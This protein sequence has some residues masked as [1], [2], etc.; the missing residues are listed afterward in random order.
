MPARTGAPPPSPLAAVAFLVLAG[1]S[2]A[3]GARPPERAAAQD[4]VGRHRP[5]RHGRDEP[6]AGHGRRDPRP[7]GRGQR[8]RRGDRRQR[9]ARRRRADVVRDRRR[10]V[11]D[12]LGREDAE[13][14]RPQRQRPGPLRR[15]DRGLTATRGSTEIPTHGPLSWSVPGCVDGWDQL[16][17]RFGT[18][19][20]ADLLAPAIA[21]RR[22]GLPRQRDHRRRLAGVGA[23]LWPR[24]RPRPPASSPA[25]SAPRTGDVFRNPGLARS[26]RADRRRTAATPSTAA[27]S[28]TRSS[29]TRSRS[30]AC[31][32]ART[33]R[34]TR[35]PG[36]SPSRPTT[37]ATT[38]GSCPPTARGSPPSRCSTCSSRTTSRRWARTRPRRST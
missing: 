21:L 18:K 13:A 4:A 10:P 33:S 30:A 22:G 5:A 31:S 14:L 15:D 32:P 11:R 19:P 8:G 25:A 20:L 37:A 16:R 27:R 9:R 29:P 24:S 35:A 23:R 36:S 34:T 26:L 12:R 7:P 38:S 6:A 17:A 28:P 1:Y 2:P 3:R